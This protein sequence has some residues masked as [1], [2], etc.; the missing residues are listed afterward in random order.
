MALQGPSA[1]PNL[2][3]CINNNLVMQQVKFDNNL[4]LRAVKAIEREPGAQAP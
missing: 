2:D 4:K 3:R 1:Q